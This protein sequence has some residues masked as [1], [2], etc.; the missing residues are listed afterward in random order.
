MFSKHLTLRSIPQLL[1]VLALLL[2]A[3][4]IS[5][6]R[7]QD[8]T[9]ALAPTAWQTGATGMLSTQ[10]GAAHVGGLGFVAKVQN[11]PQLI[12]RGGVQNAADSYV[13]IRITGPNGITLGQVQVTG[14][15]GGL[16]AQAAD[17]SH[18][19][20]TFSSGASGMAFYV[21]RMSPAVAL[22]SSAT[23]LSLFTGSLPRYTISGGEIVRM[24]DG[25]VAPKYVAYPTSGGVQVK[26]LGS[27]A[28][29]LTGI[30]ANWAL[31][32]YG[33]NSHIVDTRM[34]LSYE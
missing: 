27:T 19:Q 23:A 29:A 9:Q 24:A 12:L 11:W 22:Q 10:N 13:G 20:L 26:A 2:S 31:V 5:P 16:S 14:S 17:W 28:T 4:G 25:P 30:S 33:N 34:P 6:V 7:A 8:G 18:N 3:I 32:W 1:L 21:S 15:G